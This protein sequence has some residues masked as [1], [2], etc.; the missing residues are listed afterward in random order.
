MG[1]HTD[2]RDRT[3]CLTRLLYEETDEKHPLTMTQIIQRLQDK[4]VPAERKSIYRDLAAMNKQGFPVEYRPGKLGGWYASGR[5]MSLAELQ[6][7][8]DAV[9]VYRWLP[10]ALRQR[11]LD[12][13]TAFFPTGQRE[14]LR[15][16]VS[17]SHQGAGDPEEVRRALDRIH[18]AIQTKRAL[19]F[20]PLDYGPDR[21][22]VAAGPAQVVSPK[23]LLW[24][25]EGYHLL[26]WDHRAKHLA[27]YRP[28]RMTQVLVTGM[29]AL[30]PDPDPAL[31]TATPFGVEPNRRERVCLRFSPSLTGEILDRFGS[32]AELTAE[33][34]SLTVTADV[35]L[36][37]AFWA[38]LTTHGEEATLLAPAWAAN[39]WATRYRPRPYRQTP[40]RRQV[41]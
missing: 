5:P 28:D 10:S 36:G 25:E 40:R 19:S 34:N 2:Q 7:V 24:W 41:V 8:I 12:K 1:K 32:A 16:P 17:L 23:G 13:L 6:A 4:G 37:P 14:Q 29:P 33:D 21:Q 11:L 18:T 31:W 26:G 38:W 35:I 22:P 15:R 3:L 39:L 30:G 20:V 27:L 9:A